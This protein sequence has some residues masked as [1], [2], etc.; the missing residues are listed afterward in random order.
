MHL[1]EFYNAAPKGMQDVED[2]HS[3]P[4]WGDSRKTKG[5]TLGMINKIRRMKEVR[6]YE[7]AQD[8]K[9]I[10]KQYSPPAPEGAL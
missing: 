10:R 4:R 8:L 2:D 7:R 9:R 3:Q 5:L 6:S 1:F